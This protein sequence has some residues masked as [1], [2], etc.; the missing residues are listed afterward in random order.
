MPRYDNKFRQKVINYLK[1][2][3]KP[4]KSKVIK[5][6][7]IARQ[8]FYDWIELDRQGKLFTVKP[9]KNGFPSRVDLTELKKYVDNNPDKYYAE[10]ANVFKISKSQVQRLITSKLGYTN[11]KNRRSTESQTKKGEKSLKNK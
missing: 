5:T 6:F 11:K 8:T 1:S 3:D 4:S 10:I 7:Q 9:K 2:D